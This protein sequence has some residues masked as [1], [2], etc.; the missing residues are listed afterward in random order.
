MINFLA[1]NE[2]EN[3][4]TN[5]SRLQ[6]GYGSNR[7][8]RFMAPSGHKAFLVS[9]VGDVELLLMHNRTHAAEYASPFPPHD[10]RL[11]TSYAGLPTTSPPESELTSLPVL[12]NW[13]SRS[14]TPRRRLPLRFKRELI[15]FW[16]AL[17][18]C[19]GKGFALLAV[20]AN[21]ML[22]NKNAPLNDNETGINRFDSKNPLESEGR[23]RYSPCLYSADEGAKEGLGESLVD[24]GR[25]HKNRQNPFEGPI[26]LPLCTPCCL[27]LCCG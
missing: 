19:I 4:C 17:R 1:G 3:T 10:Q 7:K 16:A 5:A 11:L 27:K 14:P 20:L 25:G 12:S 23:I 24:C 6:I 22:E 18:L 2:T 13:V 26:W 21:R 15:G 8:T 9:N